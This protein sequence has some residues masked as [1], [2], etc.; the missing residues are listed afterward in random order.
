MPMLACPMQVTHDAFLSQEAAEAV[1]D[2]EV[3]GAGRRLSFWPPLLSTFS[4][5]TRLVLRGHFITALPHS[6]GDMVNLQVCV[7]QCVEGARGRF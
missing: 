1:D 4:R 5:V 6:V 3:V 7:M 2:V